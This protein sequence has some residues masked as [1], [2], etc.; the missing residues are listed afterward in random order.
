MQ[1][2]DRGSIVLESNPSLKRLLL[3]D[4]FS[5]SADSAVIDKREII[6]QASIHQISEFGVLIPSGIDLLGTP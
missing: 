5:I 1:A 2:P 3:E 6:H 4:N